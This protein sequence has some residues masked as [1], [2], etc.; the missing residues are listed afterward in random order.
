M[1][2][3]FY[4]F[5]IAELD[6]ASVSAIRDG[7]FRNGEPFACPNGCFETGKKWPYVW[8][9]DTA[10]AAHL[11]IASLDP[12]RDRGSLELKISERR[13][14]GDLQIVQD[15]GT[16]GS[17]PVST[18]RVVWALGARS[19]IAQLSGEERDAFA[20]TAEGNARLLRLP[21]FPGPDDGTVS[22]PEL[23][24]ITSWPALRT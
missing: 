2:D 7:A 24:R 4:Q 9:R 15:T 23:S 16:G 14:G 12:T 3:A 10:Y 13:A 18:D 8:T 20:R 5:V 6:E 19:V 21:S 17:Y 22:V 1:F 11:G